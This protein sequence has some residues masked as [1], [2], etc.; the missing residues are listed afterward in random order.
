MKTSKIEKKVV[1]CASR[2]EFA[3]TVDEIARLDI[4]RQQLEA[5]L[6]KRHQEVD[7]KFGERLDTVKKD[8]DR[9]MEK[10]KPY[11]VAHQEELC[12]KD[13]KQGET[14]LAIF[15][16]RTGMP[17]LVKK[18]KTALKDIAADWFLTDTLKP[19]VSVAYDVA[20][21]KVIQLWKEDLKKFNDVI[22]KSVTV[23]QEDAFWVEPKTD[24]QM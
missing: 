10:A 16:I 21:D 15:G 24:E 18:V 17:K 4:A 7:D 3:E 9:L 23:T 22:P 2:N 1:P 11:F 12:A 8:I 13:K 19:F 20:K 6:A 14:K 5:E